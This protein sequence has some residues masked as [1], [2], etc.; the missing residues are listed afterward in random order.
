MCVLKEIQYLLS[1]GFMLSISYAGFRV[2]YLIDVGEKNM[3]SYM[4]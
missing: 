2:S 1:I 4:L 3:L